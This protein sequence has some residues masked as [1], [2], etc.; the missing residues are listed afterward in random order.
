MDQPQSSPKADQAP[1]IDFDKFSPTRSYTAARKRKDIAMRVLI[2]LA[3][4]VGSLVFNGVCVLL[5]KPMKAL[6]IKSVTKAAS[7]A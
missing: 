4:V 1:A 6:A 2:I 7:N 3:F 5:M